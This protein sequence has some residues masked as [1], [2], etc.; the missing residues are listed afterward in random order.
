MLECKHPERSTKGPTRLQK[1]LQQQPDLDLREEFSKAGPAKA[2]NSTESPSYSHKRDEAIYPQFY[3]ALTTYWLICE[4]MRFAKICYYSRQT[5]ENIVWDKIDALYHS[6]KILL[7]AIQ[8]LEVYD[9]VG[10]YLI[11]QLEYA[12]LE[13]F[14][15]WV[16]NKEY[17]W[18]NNTTEFGWVR[19]LHDMRVVLT[20]ADVVELLIFT[21]HWKQTSER[22]LAWGPEKKSDYL[23]QRLFFAYGF[24]GRVGEV[25]SRESPDTSYTVKDLESPIELMLQR[26]PAIPG[27]YWHK[28][29]RDYRCNKWK[30]DARGKA[31]LWKFSD[32]A[33]V[34]CL[35][36]LCGQAASSSL[37]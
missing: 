14:I 18:P 24:P 29:W 22:K 23:K 7:E 5:E 8:T 3:V 12:K 27:Q 28:I 4:A 33:I 9:F 19:F 25:D 2:A 30:T 26:Y 6:R 17:L 16:G 34:D 37:Q 32:Q 31:L 35:L 11:R 20:P 13:T 36:E 15:Q 1:L 10:D 21:C